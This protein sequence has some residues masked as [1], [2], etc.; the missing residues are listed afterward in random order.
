QLAD[1]PFEIGALLQKAAGFIDKSVPDIDIRDAGLA[2]RI[3]IERIQKRRFGGRLDAAY[4]R[5]THPQHRHTLGLEYADHLVDLFSV[6][7]APAF[8]A[9]LIE[10]VRRARALLRSC[11]RRSATAV[12]GIVRRQF[13]IRYLRR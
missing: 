4:R 7:F 6:E 2:G 10:A 11:G 9:K 13:G 3:A 8:L 12:G 5:Q 1:L